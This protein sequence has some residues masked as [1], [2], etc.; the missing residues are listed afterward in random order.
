MRRR[1]YN[2][3][4]V[5]VR[6]IEH[7]KICLPVFILKI[8]WK[9]KDCFSALFLWI[10]S[11]PVAAWKEKSKN[12]YTLYLTAT[13]SKNNKISKLNSTRARHTLYLYSSPHPKNYVEKIFA[14]SPWKNKRECSASSLSLSLAS[15]LIQHSYIPLTDLSPSDLLVESVPASHQ[16]F[17]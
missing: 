4:S 16:A 1:G 7:L 2:V 9:S 10:N 12:R 14:F 11:W 17:P 5:Y 3:L 13:L 6:I 8:P 15:L